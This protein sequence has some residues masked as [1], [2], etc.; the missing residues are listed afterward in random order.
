MRYFYLIPPVIIF[1]F[2][3]LMVFCLIISPAS[4]IVLSQLF[5]L[6]LL[7]FSFVAS[8]IVAIVKIKGKYAGSQEPRE[9][10]E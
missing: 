7:L 5:I 1:S 6:L 9:N 2:I 4:D 3:G 10:T 8:I